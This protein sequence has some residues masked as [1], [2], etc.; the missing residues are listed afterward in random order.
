MAIPG[1]RESSLVGEKRAGEHSRGVYIIK[2][3][4]YAPALR[5]AL[6]RSEAEPE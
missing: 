3:I 6:E 2:I 1:E 4:Q 5:L